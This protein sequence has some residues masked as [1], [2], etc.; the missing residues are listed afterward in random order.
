MTN[1]VIAP[2]SV[3]PEVSSSTM[4]GRA[5]WANQSDNQEFSKTFA[6]TLKQH[7]QSAADAQSKHQVQSSNDTSHSQ[8]SSHK[9]AYNAHAK[10]ASDAKG[11]TLPANGK[12]LQDK[13]E[14]AN[15][16]GVDAA[17]DIS[18]TDK[19]EA[20]TSVQNTTHQAPTTD[21]ASQRVTSSSEKDKVASSDTA[22]VPEETA[23]VT[24]ASIT[25]DNNTVLDNTLAN[26]GDT[27]T[28]ISAGNVVQNNLPGDPATAVSARQVAG[29][30]NPGE[31]RSQDPRLTVPSVQQQSSAT[32]ALADDS[33]SKT[34]LAQNS[35]TQGTP[36]QQAA[37]AHDLPKQSFSDQIKQW[38]AAKQAVPVT[39]TQ[40]A[41]SA[42]SLGNNTVTSLSLDSTSLSPH[43]QSRF[44]N[45]LLFEKLMAQP[46][47]SNLRPGGTSINALMTNGVTQQSDTAVQDNKL[48]ATDPMAQMTV[49]TMDVR[50]AAA[51]NTNAI[52]VLTV[53]TPMQH[54]GWAQDVG[55][56]LT[57][58][59]NQDMQ[60]AQLQMN[61]RHLGPLEVRIN[62]GHDQQVNVSFIAHNSAA[63]D[64]IDGAMPRLRDMLG[65]Q[66]LGLSDFNVSQESFKNSQDQTP[67]QS[68]TLSGPYGGAGGE[69]VDNVEGVPAATQTHWVS[70]RIVDY[71]A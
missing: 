1:V 59:L 38:V 27:M 63:R 12:H 28:V 50:P 70:D 2:K 7:K 41:Q 60:Q 66:G 37:Q 54:P 20:D 31:V 35:I 13:K 19:R 68:E 29:K 56:K 14:G 61:P 16:D 51:S 40:G 32:T 69:E 9:E 46:G 36:M 17:A 6:E 23:S 67:A 39:T 25:K 8:S 62:M 22:S 44:N 53:P 65:Q 30:S 4:P 34:V 5:Q 3:E 10:K 24:D 21:A 48:V 45:H 47:A 58:M 49:N 57:F 15:A 64:A 11:S 42:S 71:F 18:V 26:L 52:P 55:H 43:D 33:S